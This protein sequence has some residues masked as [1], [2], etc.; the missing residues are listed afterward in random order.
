MQRQGRVERKGDLRIGRRRLHLVNRKGRKDKWKRE[1][2]GKGGTKHREVD[3]SSKNK[4]DVK[5]KL[6]N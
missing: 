6:E 2:N 4:S 1:G 3:V 5:E